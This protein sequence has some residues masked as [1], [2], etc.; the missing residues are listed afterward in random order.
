MNR[1]NDE[2][3]IRELLNERENLQMVNSLYGDMINF[4][5]EN[6][7]SNDDIEEDICIICYDNHANIILFPC[8]HDNICDDCYFKLEDNKCPFC[9]K[10]ISYI[11]SKL[12]C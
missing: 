6:L 10:N 5:S 2:M 3:I 1:N 11:F 8:M 12:K 4:L 7:D 9:R